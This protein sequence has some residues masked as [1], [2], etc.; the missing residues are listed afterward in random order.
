MAEYGS[1]RDTTR[2]MNDYYYSVARQTNYGKP[3]TR[4]MRDLQDG[5]YEAYSSYKTRQKEFERA[6]AA[7]FAAEERCKGE[8]N[9]QTAFDTQRK[10]YYTSQTGGLTPSH[11]RQ[12]TP[13][14]ESW[15]GAAER[16]AQR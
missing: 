10:Q 13:S 14:A 11:H 12:L 8:F 9:R 6:D 15:K 4:E 1:N 3:P 7:H 2:A 5:S 16:Y